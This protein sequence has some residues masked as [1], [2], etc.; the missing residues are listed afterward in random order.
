MPG[1]RQT[2]QLESAGDRGMI[3]LHC[4]LLPAVDDGPETMEQAVAMARAAHD[5]GIQKAIVTPHL[6]LGRYEND[7]DSIRMA[8]HAFSAELKR[9]RIPL[10]ISYAAEVRICPELTELVENGTA[11]YVGELEGKK[12]L[13]LEFP[14]SHIPT[15]SDK[16]I[17]WLLGHGVRPMIAHPERNKDV[18]RKFDK[19]L[20]FV[21]MGC[22]IQV[23][24]G[25]VAGRFGPAARQRANDLLE[26]GFVHVLASDAHNLDV[27]RPELEMG[28]VAAER[29]IGVHASWALVRDTPHAISRSRFLDVDLDRAVEDVS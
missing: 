4:H 26:H 18:I 3:D 16:M 19:I 8:A 17:E 10:Q 21:E 5:A 13:L 23:T 1:C 28:R 22:L 2:P 15:G 6:H 27:R 9:R 24:A 14:H 29:I 7:L 12:I 25:S 11:P 20:P